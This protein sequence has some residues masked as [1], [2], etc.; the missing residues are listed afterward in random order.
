MK[1]SDTGV[2]NENDE[3]KPEVRTVGGS[4]KGN[5]AALFVAD[6]D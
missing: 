3:R 6:L 1:E 4:G 2:G 5:K